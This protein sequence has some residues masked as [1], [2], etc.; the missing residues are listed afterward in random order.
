VIWGP[1]FLTSSYACIAGRAKGSVRSDDLLEKNT[2]VG[3][4]RRGERDKREY[5]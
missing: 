3:V 4:W 5:V 1:A 2:E